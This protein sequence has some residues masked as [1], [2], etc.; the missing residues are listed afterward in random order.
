MKIRIKGSASYPPLQPVD[1][2]VIGF[3]G[4]VE[5]HQAQVGEI[6]ENLEKGEENQVKINGRSN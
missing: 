4:D 1:D 3:V 2:D 5:R 6:P